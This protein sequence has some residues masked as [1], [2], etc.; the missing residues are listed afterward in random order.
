MCGSNNLCNLCGSPGSTAPGAP[1]VPCCKGNRCNTGCCVSGAYDMPY[2]VARNA[3]CFSGGGICSAGSSCGAG[4]GALGAPCC[5]PD[6]RRACGAS[7]TTCLLVGAT[8]TCVSCGR[9][10]DPCCTVDTG[11]IGA[12]AE[13]LH[14]QYLP[15]GET[16][17]Q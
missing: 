3:T 7:G 10:G 13:N 1:Q 16:K 5:T 6:N 4:C 12:C 2:C 15:G 17:C 11:F 14:C 8:L 9:A